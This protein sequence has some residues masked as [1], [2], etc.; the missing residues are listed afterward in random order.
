MYK[1]YINDT[2]VWLV[3]QDEPEPNG[4]EGERLELY[5]HGKPKFLL[6]LVDQLE[7]SRR[8]SAAIVTGASAETIF[9]DF[10]KAFHIVP[11]AGGLV[12]DPAGRGLFIF[13]RG[14]WD[15][16]KGKID[17]GET[18]PEAALREVTEETGLQRLQLVEP[19]VTTWHT[20]RQKGKRF[21]KP[22]H[23]FLM[24][25]AADELRLQR[26][27]DIEA[28]KWMMPEDFLNHPPGPVYGSILDVVRTSLELAS[29]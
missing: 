26:E 12:L 29:R 11:A 13:R 1:I 16:P 25:S 3:G 23:W 18:P 28:A 9:E 4:L 19:L 10:K 8:F 5:Y 24:H 17:E 2:P 6:N 15:L 20:Y 7:K 22:T 21:L 14:F 27:E